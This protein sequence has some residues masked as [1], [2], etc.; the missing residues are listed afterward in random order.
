MDFNDQPAFM[1]RKIREIGTDGRLAPKMRAFN[2]P[3]PQMPPQ[4]LLGISHRAA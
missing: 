1:A 4:L 2:R 3:P